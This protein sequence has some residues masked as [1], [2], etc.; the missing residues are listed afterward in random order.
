M[1]ALG[2]SYADIM[3][4]GLGIYAT[5]ESTR[6]ARVAA[7]ITS[8][9]V[10]LNTMVSYGTTTVEAKSGYG[11]EIVTELKQLDVIKT[12]MA[13]HP[14]DLVPT[15]LGAHAVP[16]GI[17]ADEFADYVCREGIPA[18]VHQGVARFCD[19]FCE[20]G[21]FTPAQTERILLAGQALG[22]RS[23]IH[24]DEL[25]DTGGA[26][27]A[28]RLGAVSADHL[29]CVSDEGLRALAGSDTVAVLLP[30]TATFLGLRR[31]APARAMID[32]GIP[33]AIATD[34]NPGSCYCESLPLMMTFACSQL[35]LSASEAFTAVTVNAAAAVGMESV[36]GSLMPGMQ[37]DAVI[38]DADD[39]HMLP[40]HMGARLASVVIK[41][42]VVIHGSAD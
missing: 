33:V 16:H 7:L 17:S 36:V 28:A 23:K 34:F 21:V 35:G 14:V 9:R 27:L 2:R 26:A 8:A 24:A 22:L 1:R 5:V 39:Y 11:L 12:L 18:A 40:Y 20:T 37:A 19:V 6:E 10:H 4:A 13:T 30:G 38:W 29:H 31:H 15:F 3:A 32:L 25:T 41:R 42:G